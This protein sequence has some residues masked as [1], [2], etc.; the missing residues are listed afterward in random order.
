MNAQS[1]K[2]TRD[3][4]KQAIERLME[5]LSAGV[6]K[7]EMHIVNDICLSLTSSLFLKSLLSTTGMFLTNET[8]VLSAYYLGRCSTDLF[9]NPFDISSHH[10]FLRFII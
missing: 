3:N 6:D 9:M 5:A 2:A 8:A 4:V 10:S 1:L 7:L